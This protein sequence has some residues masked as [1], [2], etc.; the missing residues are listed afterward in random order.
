MKGVRGAT[1]YLA[2]GCAQRAAGLVDPTLSS[3]VRAVPRRRW[4]R[5]LRSA[6]RGWW[7]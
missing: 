4:R 6:R 2:E 1:Q 5:A 3:G 7:T